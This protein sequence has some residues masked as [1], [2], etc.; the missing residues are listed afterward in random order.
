MY[1]LGNKNYA[2]KQNKKAKK[3]INKTTTNETAHRYNTVAHSG[4][5]NAKAHEAKQEKQKKNQKFSHSGTAYGAQ[6]KYICTQIT[7]AQSSTYCCGR[8]TRSSENYA[9]TYTL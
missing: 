4:D 2:E 6:K 1:A 7:I 8:W 5:Q 9:H 3:W